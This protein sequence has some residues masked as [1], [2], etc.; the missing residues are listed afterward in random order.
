MNTAEFWIKTIFLAGGSLFIGL[1][2]NWKIGLG[3]ALLA[4]FLDTK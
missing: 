3:A 2:T 1:G 4:I